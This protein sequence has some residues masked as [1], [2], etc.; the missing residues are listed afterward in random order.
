MTAPTTQ[1]VIELGAEVGFARVGVASA[2]P[3]RGGELQAW[4]DAGSHGEMAYM[5]RDVAT[6]IDPAALLAGARSVI[7]VADRHTADAEP[8]LGGREGRIARY[9]RGR[10]YHK[11][12]KRKLHALCDALREEASEDTFRACVDTAPLMERDHAA[13]AGIGAMGKHTLLIEQGVGS[14]MLLGA[15]VTTLDLKPTVAEDIDPCGT[16]TRCI[17]AC[18]TDA[19]T[20]FSVDATRC[21]SYLTIEHRGRIDPDLHAGIGTWLF[22][23]D[24]CQEVCPH[25]APTLR[26]LKAGKNPSLGGD[27]HALDVLD[28]LNWDE[29]A[30][31]AAVSGTAMTRVKLD[32]WKRNALIV[33]GNLLSNEDDPPLRARI[34]AMAQDAGASELVRETACAVTA[35]A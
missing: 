10:D 11:V 16:C 26:S 14:W 7:C 5:A 18:P 9:A 1:R 19:I 2:E 22:G 17:E 13:A 31:R 35:S 23:C 33:A 6:R 25:N 27:A 29:D 8:T 21:V 34:A 12:I 20:P 30:R 28:V 4:I 15:I 3:R 32:Q 24:A